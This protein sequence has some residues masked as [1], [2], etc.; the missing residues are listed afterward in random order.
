MSRIPFWGDLGRRLFLLLGPMLLATVVVAVPAV[1]AGSP[2][3]VGDITVT[4]VGNTVTVSGK[5]A[6]LGSESQVHIVVTLSAQCINRGDVHPKAANKASFTAMGDFPVQNGK[7]NFTL[8]VTATFQPK[9]SPPMTL[10]FS[11][12]KVC[13]TTNNICQTFS[14][15]F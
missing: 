12:V 14:G 5:E 15:P 9:C 10:E 1:R 7:A 13:D 11:E 4:R 6:G 3:F 2:H 8:S